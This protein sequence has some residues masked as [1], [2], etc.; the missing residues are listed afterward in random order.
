MASLPAGTR[1]SP[2]RRSSG[3]TLL[4]RFWFRCRRGPLRRSRCRL[5][6]SLPCSP[7]CNLGCL[8]VLERRYQRA[9]HDD[10]CQMPRGV[11][12]PFDSFAY[13]LI[14]IAAGG[15]AKIVKSAANS[16]ALLVI[17]QP[18]GVL[19]ERFLRRA[20]DCLGLVACF[21]E[22]T[23]ANVLFGEFERVDQHLLDL[24]ICQPVR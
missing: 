11:V 13:Q 3:G 2:A 21:D 14:V 6:L 10:L 19:G 5:L 4:C 24:F 12:E 17:D 16:R 1:R 20:H 15:L 22:L 9:V 7:L 18:L 8:A 23:L